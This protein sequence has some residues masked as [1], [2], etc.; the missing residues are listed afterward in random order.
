MASGKRHCDREVA[1]VSIVNSMCQVIYSSFVKPSVP[2]VS[3]L[4]PLTGI[5]SKF[6]R[7]STLEKKTWRTRPLWRSAKPP[8]SA[9]F[10]PTASWSVRASVM[11]SPFPL[12]SPDINWMGFQKGRD[13]AKAIDI[14]H[15]FK[16]E[17]EDASPSRRRGKEPRKVVVK[18]LRHEALYLTGVDIQVGA[19]ERN[20]GRAERTIRRSTRCTR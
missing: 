5:Q 11:V 18:S 10:P 19:R 2:I 3:Y 4:T 20:E 15:W 8:S 13:F 14:L 16:Y 9:F 1:R 12:F 6:P 7:F 17:V